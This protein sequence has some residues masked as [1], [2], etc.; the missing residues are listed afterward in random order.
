MEYS[1][2]APAPSLRK[3]QGRSGERPGR[4]DAIFSFHS[5]VALLKLSNTDTQFSAYS[6]F[7]L[8]SSN[9]FRRYPFSRRVA[10]RSNTRYLMLSRR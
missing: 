7:P 1:H 2:A 8:V 9:I 5:F 6:L 3:R 4:E 10:S